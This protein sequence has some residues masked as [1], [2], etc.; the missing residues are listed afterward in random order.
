ML[1]SDRWHSGRWR[2]WTGVCINGGVANCFKNE[3]VTTHCIHSPMKHSDLI[4]YD[5]KCIAK[6]Y[7]KPPGEQQA[8]SRDARKDATNAD[9]HDKA[10]VSSS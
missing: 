9:C 4:Q 1:A 10:F 3:N 2:D 5:N 6:R 8:L 7:Y